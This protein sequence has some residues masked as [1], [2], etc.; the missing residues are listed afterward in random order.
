M[1]YD[2]FAFKQIVRILNGKHDEFLED[3]YFLMVQCYLHE[4]NHHS[5]MLI[6]KIAHCTYIYIIHK[7]NDKLISISNNI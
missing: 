2:L 6:K 5:V 7:N 4:H 3:N 1:L